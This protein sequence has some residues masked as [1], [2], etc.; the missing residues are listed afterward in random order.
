M[1]WKQRDKEEKVKPLFGNTSTSDTKVKQRVVTDT[2]EFTESFRGISPRTAKLYNYTHG[3]YNNQEA[4]FAAFRD[5][6]GLVAAQHVRLVN[7]K[8]FRWTGT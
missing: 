4:H 1:P 7:P 2:H 3:T 6:D 5:K 8:G